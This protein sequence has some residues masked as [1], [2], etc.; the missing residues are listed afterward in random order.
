MGDF[1]QAGERPDDRKVVTEIGVVVYDR[2]PE[3]AWHEN[4][5]KLF[6][7]WW[8]YEAELVDYPVLREGGMTPW[9]AVNRLFGAH[10]VLLEPRWPS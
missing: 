1:V 10:R 6:G 7:Q 9:E 2:G 4:D 5:R 3:P 8:R